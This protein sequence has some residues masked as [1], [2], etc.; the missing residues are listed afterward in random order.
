MGARL[1]LDRCPRR[2][3]KGFAESAH[4]LGIELL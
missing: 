4:A 1:R 3:S 2:S